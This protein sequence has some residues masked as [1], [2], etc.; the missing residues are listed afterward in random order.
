MIPFLIK[1]NNNPEVSFLEIN[2]YNSII[3]NLNPPISRG[4][5]VNLEK[6][7]LQFHQKNGGTFAHRDIALEFA[8]S[9]SPKVKFRL[10]VGPPIE[11][12]DNQF[13]VYIHR[14]CL[15]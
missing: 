12:L 3:S 6:M 4:L 8:S 11:I 1:K 10:L 13:F 14:G 5:R 15:F 2:E 7:L 9:I